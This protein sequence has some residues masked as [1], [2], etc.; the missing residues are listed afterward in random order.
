MP[1]DQERRAI[2]D[3]M[4]TAYRE[5]RPFYDLWEAAGI[6]SAFGPEDPLEAVAKYGSVEAHNRVVREA[7]DRVDRAKA[8]IREGAD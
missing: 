5:A 6:A 1:S 4:R 8:A 3:F 7:C 2:V